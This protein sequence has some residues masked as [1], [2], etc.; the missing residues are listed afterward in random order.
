MCN[1]YGTFRHNQ[2]LFH[3]KI[4][5]SSEKAKI[6]IYEF[7]SNKFA[8]NMFCKIFNLTNLLSS[9]QETVFSQFP[10]HGIS[11]NIHH[12]MVYESFTSKAIFLFLKNFNYSRR[13]IKVINVRIFHYLNNVYHWHITRTDVYYT[14]S[15]CLELN[16]KAVS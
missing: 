16:Q 8:L 1:L 7:D 12:K 3:K 6:F 5:S 14:L 2:Y 9:R 13:I 10:L 11:F 15:H 4:F